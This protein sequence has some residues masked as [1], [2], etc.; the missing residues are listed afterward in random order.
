MALKDVTNRHELVVSS[1]TIQKKTNVSPKSLLKITKDPKRRINCVHLENAIIKAMAGHDYSQFQVN[2]NILACQIEFE[3]NEYYDSI[4][5][6]SRYDNQVISRLELI[7]QKDDHFVKRLVTGKTTP[8]EFAR[9][10]ALIKVSQKELDSMDRGQP[11]TV[12]IWQTEAIARQEMAKIWHAY[13][14]MPSRASKR[15][16]VDTKV[17]VKP[18]PT[19]IVSWICSKCGEVPH[20]NFI[21]N[22]FQCLS[23]KKVIIL[24]FDKMTKSL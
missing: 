10:P 3:I 16:R 18:K 17:L 4:I 7:R 1:P 23:C 21:D 20:D 22:Y 9:M 12:S 11:T 15:R 5:T 8:Y 24:E 19:S 2:V 13:Y 14:S 6:P